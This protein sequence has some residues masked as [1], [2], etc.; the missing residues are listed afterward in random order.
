M[1]QI[2]GLKGFYALLLNCE[3]PGIISLPTKPVDL[4]LS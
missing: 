4:W 2:G 3:Y 1:T